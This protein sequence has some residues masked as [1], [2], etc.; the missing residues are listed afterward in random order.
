M[1]RTTITNT[2]TTFNSSIV[3]SL[4]LGL[5]EC[6][7][8]GHS[9]MAIFEA[10]HAAIHRSATQHNAA[11]TFAAHSVPAIE[12]DLWSI[13]VVTSVAEIWVGHRACPP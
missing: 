1:N 13:H 8:T 3:A 12:V 10:H 5:R 9:L 11:L 4:M 2:K 7:P 6:V